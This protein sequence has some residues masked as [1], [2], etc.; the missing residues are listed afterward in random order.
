[1]RVRYNISFPIF[2]FIKSTSPKKHIL[3]TSIDKRDLAN[4]Q[5]ELL[6]RN[7]VTQLCSFQII[8]DQPLNPQFNFCNY[9]FNVIV[10]KHAQ[11]QLISV[12]EK[13]CW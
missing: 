11:L 2:A 7:L 12:K 3:Q 6:M 1:M 13:N 9:I 10:N 5:E 4:F 8:N